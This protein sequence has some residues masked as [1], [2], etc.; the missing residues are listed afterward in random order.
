VA[1]VHE[2]LAFVDS[3][4]HFWDLS[5]Q[6]HGW[7]SDPEVWP[8]QEA[9]LGDYAIL[10]RNY[11]VDDLLDQ[12]DGCNLT[13]VVHVQA[14]WGGD[15]VDETRWLQKL[16]DET[17]FPQAIVA[18]TDLRSV[19][20][21]EEL[22]RHMQSPNMRGIRMHGLMFPDDLL[23]DP[24]FRRG[25][26]ALAG[27]GLNYDLSLSWEQ[28][29]KGLDL[30][31]AFPMCQLVVNHTG[32]PLQR[33]EAYFRSWR[34]GM[35]T[36]AQ[37]PN[38]AVKISGLGMGDHDWTVESLRP[39]VLETISLFGIDRCMFGSNWPV[40]T[41]YGPPRRLIDAY[42]QITEG[43]SPSEQRRL[44]SENAERIYRT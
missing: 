44:F 30:A 33:G 35:A 6:N 9:Y 11:L 3:A 16:A 14:D 37:A 12:F 27:R 36:L 17:G 20:A 28:M 31:G 1:E 42:R 34:G 41:L 23:V 29:G 39:W 2:D 40:D 18:F 43:F 22:D 15:P 19:G 13:K 10:K 32:M 24:A 25:F 8:S 5:W 26:A 21:A 7:L 38:I 4:I